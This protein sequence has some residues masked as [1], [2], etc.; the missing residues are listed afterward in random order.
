MKDGLK[1]KMNILIILGFA[2]FLTCFGNTAAAPPKESL[3]L[4]EQ[5]INGDFSNLIIPKNDDTLLQTLEKVYEVAETEGHEW[6]EFDLNGD[7]INELILRVSESYNEEM[8]RIVAVFTFD[9]EKQESRLVYL[10]TNDLPRF[11]FLSRNGNMIW[12]H[13]S[14]GAI[15]WDSYGHEVFDDDWNRVRLYT[16]NITEIDDLSE[17]PDMRETG[18]YFHL[19]TEL[20][21]ERLDES[22][23]MRMFEEMTGFC[24]S[25][26]WQSS[27]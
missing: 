18:V 14:Y 6:I 9:I 8:K 13:F 23:F 26:P 22:S 27:P 7:G 2:F 5:I 24:F 11:L 12:Y 25:S 16:L 21:R 19:D 10:H 4:P 3:T 1:I 17:L 15:L 20:G